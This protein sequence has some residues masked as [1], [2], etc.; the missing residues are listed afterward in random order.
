MSSRLRIATSGV[1]RPALGL[2]GRPYLM[3]V[4][5]LLVTRRLPDRQ[6]NLIIS[7]LDFSFI[8]TASCSPNHR[9][10]FRRET[11]RHTSLQSNLPQPIEDLLI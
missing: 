1:E 5:S 3:K 8:S 11:R 7:G 4:C 6:A 2:V 10:Q 9:N